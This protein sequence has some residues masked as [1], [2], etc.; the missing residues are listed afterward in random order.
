M[1]VTASPYGLSEN[2]RFWHEGDELPELKVRS[3]REAEL[4]FMTI[5]CFRCAEQYILTKR[6]DWQTNRVSITILNLW[7]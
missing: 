4:L 5:T 1:S 6:F 3:E 2:V 7:M